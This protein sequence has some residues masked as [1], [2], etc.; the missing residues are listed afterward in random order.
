MSKSSNKRKK[1]DLE[2]AEP[3]PSTPVVFK[4]EATN[5]KTK[6]PDQDLKD[7]KPKVK[8]T[9]PGV[10]KGGQPPGFRVLTSENSSGRPGLCKI[11][12]KTSSDGSDIKMLEHLEDSPGFQTLNDK[13][14]KG[15]S[16]TTTPD[17]IEML[18]QAFITVADKLLLNSFYVH[19]QIDKQ[20]LSSTSTGEIVHHKEA[21]SSGKALNKKGEYTLRPRSVALAIQMDPSLRSLFGDVKI[22]SDTRPPLVF[23]AA[24]ATTA[25]VSEDGGKGPKAKKGKTAAPKKGAVAPTSGA[26]ANLS[27]VLKDYDIKV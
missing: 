15:F 3:T 7:V 24:S 18:D 13:G 19:F 11:L 4:G 27:K 17:T 1:V 9:P 25:K 5:D 23:D 14:A 26:E 21:A 22:P 20:G 6:V 12:V 16:V 8:K 10:K 2:V